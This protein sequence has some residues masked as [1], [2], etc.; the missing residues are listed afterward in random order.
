[1]VSPSVHDGTPNS[2]LEAMAC[3]CLPV[4]GDLDSIREWITPGENGLLTDATDARGFG[5]ARSSKALDNKNLRH[6]AAGLNHDIILQ[7]AE[8]TRCMAEADGFYKR[9]ISRS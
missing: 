1:M 9:I 3:G 6:K 4:A 8:Y 7:R 5:R 2:L